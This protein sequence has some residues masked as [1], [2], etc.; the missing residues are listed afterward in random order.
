MLGVLLSPLLAAGCGGAAPA[1]AA[2]PTAPASA[3]GATPASATTAT[4]VAGG[5]VQATAPP[6]SVAPTATPATGFAAGLDLVNPRRGGRLVEG[7][8][9]EVRTLNPLFATDPVSSH[10]V[11]LL[12]RGLVRI[13]PTTLQ[14]E[15]DLAEGWQA[16]PDNQGYRFR[17]RPSIAFHDGHPCTAE[18][19]AFTYELLLKDT[20]AAPRQADLAAV[21][22]S[23]AVISPTEVEFRLKGVFAPFLATHAGYGIVPKHL[24]SGVE[25]AKI[26]QSE[27]SLLRP[28]GAGPYRFKEWLRGSSLTLTRFDGAIGGPPHLDEIVLRVAPSQETLLSQLKVGEIDVGLLREQ[29]VEEMSRQQNLAI[30]RVDTLSITYLGFQLDAARTALFQDRPMR[31]ALGHGLDREAMVRLGRYGLGRVAGGSVPPPSWA[32]GD[33]LSGRLAYDPAR[34]E[35]LLDGA[36]WRRGA[37]GVRERD[38]KKLAFELLANRGSGG[39]RVREQYAMLVQEAWKRLGADVKLTL[40]DFQEVVTRLRRTHEFDVYLATFAFDFDPDQRLLW[41]T[42]AYKT[43]FNASRYTNPGLDRLLTDAVQTTDQSRRRDLYL[44]AQETL[45][46]DLPAIVVDYPL[47]AYAVAKR[48]RNVIPNPSG[49]GYNAHQWWVSDGK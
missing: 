44:K 46:D 9:N 11:S 29:D 2:S 23:V 25:P 21:L 13:N 31:Q 36:G 3:A 41:S 14:P 24:L 26:E 40:V 16:T 4:P 34:A 12:F 22:D 10:A 17:L 8:V 43:G 39:N 28:V 27:F 15:A 6:T 19:V 48:A 18:D 49:L 30:S 7:W 45:L 20:V 1:P 35:A 5:P 37:D 32:A 33:R 38:G 42:D 47:Q